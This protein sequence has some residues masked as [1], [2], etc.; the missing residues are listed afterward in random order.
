MFIAHLPA[1]YISTKYILNKARKIWPSLGKTKLYLIVGL[2]AALLPDFDMVYFY[3]IDNRQHLHH[4]YMT[5]LPIYWAVS[6]GIWAIV[7]V[8]FKSKKSLLLSI[9]VGVNVLL[10]L[11]L[12]TFVGKVRWLYPF[13]NMDFYFFDV[14]AKHSWWVWNFVLHWTFLFELSILSVAGFILYRSF[15]YAHGKK[16]AES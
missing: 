14:P 8:I 9:I 16:G 2:I 10:H 11:F 13:S 3:L 12:D 15:G 4:G 5:H 6:I 1:G 7:S